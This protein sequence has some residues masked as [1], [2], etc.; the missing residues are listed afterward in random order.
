MVLLKPVLSG[1]DIQYNIPI[2][3][4]EHLVNRRLRNNIHK[5]YVR[6][7][8]NGSA[9]MLNL[10]MMIEESNLGRLAGRISHIIQKFQQQCRNTA[11][12]TVWDVKPVLLCFKSDVFCLLCKMYKCMTLK[13]R[14]CPSHPWAPYLTFT[15]K[16]SFQLLQW[17]MLDVWRSDCMTMCPV[18][19]FKMHCFQVFE[20]DSTVL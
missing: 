3:R 8:A 18:N 11:A 15:L 10:H 5:R 20:G 17:R 2:M 7:M 13:A 12:M 4:L 19:K 14:V 16:I 9:E 6:R 1:L